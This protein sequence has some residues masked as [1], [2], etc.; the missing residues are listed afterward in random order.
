LLFG[1]T[2]TPYRTDGVSLEKDFHEIIVAPSIEEL[3]LAGYLARIRY[4]ASTDVDF[5]DVRRTLQQEFE[6]EDAFRKVRIVVQAGDILASWKK[7]AAGKKALIY[8]CNQEHCEMVEAELQQSGI[9]AAA[10]THRTGT[11]ERDAIVA[12]FEAGILRAL[13]NCEVFTEGTDLKNVGCIIMV[14]P[15]A[16]RSLYKQMLGRG[17]RP[18]VPCVAIDLVGNYL[19]HGNILTEDPIE[20][21]KASHLLK[22]MGVVSTNDVI[23]ATRLELHVHKVE[24]ATIK[25][26]WTPSFFRG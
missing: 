3:V 8:C 15:V 7:H 20:I 17:L 1:G 6:A 16:S 25:R 21:M 18:D 10:V 4:V 5:E 2:A 22:T 12:N 26:V 14:R 9:A 23:E 24:T 11:K 19:R 13:I